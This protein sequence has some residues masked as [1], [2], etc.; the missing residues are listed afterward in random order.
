[1][2]LTGVLQTMEGLDA[3]RRVGWA[4]YYE[5]A[6]INEELLE[7]LE[8]IGNAII[9]HPRINNGDPVLELA[10]RSLAARFETT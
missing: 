1:M 10:R 3:S 9:F 5:L 8:E 6:Q 4:K 7:L 2:K